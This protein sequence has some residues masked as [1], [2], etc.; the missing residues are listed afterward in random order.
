[1]PYTA[2]VCLL[3]NNDHLDNIDLSYYCAI[4]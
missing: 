4:L 2:N 1:M 3:V